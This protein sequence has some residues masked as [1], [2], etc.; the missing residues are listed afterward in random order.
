MSLQRSSHEVEE[1]KIGYQTASRLKI[2]N[3]SREDVGTYQC[4]S[5]NSLGTSHDVI[6]IYGEKKNPAIESKICF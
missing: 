6:R 1:I 2:F 5:T 4:L 3:F